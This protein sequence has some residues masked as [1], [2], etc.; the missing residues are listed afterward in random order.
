MGNT[1]I[2]KSIAIPRCCYLYSN[3]VRVKY[4]IGLLTILYT[5]IIL[6]CTTGTCGH[7]SI[8]A[9]YIP[10]RWVLLSI[11]S[12]RNGIS[13]MNTYILT[14]MIMYVVL[15]SPSNEIKRNMHFF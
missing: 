13:V 7:T 10:G 15:R 2:S 9:A 6:Y 8:H 12:R 4:Y 5:I 3:G 11:E 1:T 14:R